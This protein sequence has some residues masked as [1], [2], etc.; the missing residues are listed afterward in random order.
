M[1]ELEKYIKRGFDEAIV[2]PSIPIR[3]VEL[4]MGLRFIQSGSTAIALLGGS[5]I[6]LGLQGPEGLEIFRKQFSKTD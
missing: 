1:V 4:V 2:K 6:L 5:L 3:I